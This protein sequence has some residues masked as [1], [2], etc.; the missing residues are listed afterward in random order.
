MGFHRVLSDFLICLAFLGVFYIL[1]VACLRVMRRFTFHKGSKDSCFEASGPK[2]VLGQ[3]LVGY[4]EL[5]DIGLAPI[6]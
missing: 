6:L 2:T 3:C 1:F 4:L 5:Q